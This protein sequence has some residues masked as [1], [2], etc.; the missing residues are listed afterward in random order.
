MS[1]FRGARVAGG[2]Y[3]FTLVT[4]RRVQLFDDPARVNILRSAMRRV[5]LKRPYAIDAMVVLPDHLHC[6]WRLPAGDWNYSARWRWIKT[7]VS[8]RVR[9][10]H[11]A[12]AGKALWQPRFWEHVIQSEEDWRRHVD[13]IHYNPVKHGLVL[14]PRD[15]PWSSFR[16]CV[17]RGWYD[18]SWGLS[19]P[20]TIA[21]MNLE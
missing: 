3:F 19:E 7:T 16:R 12:W 15:W 4:H 1:N 14:A 5:M 13:Y 17:Q 10:M 11:P 8:Q 6:I 21:T 9:E 2:V 20:A 18:P